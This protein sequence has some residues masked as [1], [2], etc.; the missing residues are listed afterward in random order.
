MRLSL[1]QPPRL[2]NNPAGGKIHAFEDLTQGRP[3][4]RIPRVADR[5]ITLGQLRSL[6]AHVVSR[7]DSEGWMDVNGQRLAADEVSMYDAVRCA[8]AV[9]S[10]APLACG[11]F[12]FTHSRHSH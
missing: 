4:A 1:V 6:W 9:A 7:C 5:G 8:R 2:T 3:P 11:A 12:L 10:H